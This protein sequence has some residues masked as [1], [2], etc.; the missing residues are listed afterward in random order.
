MNKYFTYDSFA[1][2]LQISSCYWESVQLN[3]FMFGYCPR[4]HVNTHS[5]HV[6]TL[7]LAFY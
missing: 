6:C 3:W 4:S 5:T 7:V 1:L 2:N